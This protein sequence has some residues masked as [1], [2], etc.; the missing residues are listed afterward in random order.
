MDSLWEDTLRSLGKSKYFDILVK[1]RLAGRTTYFSDILIIFCLR[2]NEPYS[3]SGQGVLGRC[4]TT[5]CVGLFLKIVSGKGLGSEK[6]SR[7]KYHL[8]VCPACTSCVYNVL[9]SCNRWMGKS[10]SLYEHCH[11]TLIIWHGT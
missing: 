2:I 5:F 9:S 1:E 11:G 6:L 8:I 7:W 3:I 10:S 4:L